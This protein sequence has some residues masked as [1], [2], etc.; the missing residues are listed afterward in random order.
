MKLMIGRDGVPSILVGTYDFVDF[1]HFKFSVIN[2]CWDGVFTNGYI[3]VTGCPGGDNT[4]L[5]KMEILCDNQDRLRG[6]WPD[7]FDHFD[8]PS[9]VGPVPKPLPANWDDDI[10]F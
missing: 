6:D 3:T 10:P 8:D 4:I 5:E 2:G 1:N 7:V 9:Y